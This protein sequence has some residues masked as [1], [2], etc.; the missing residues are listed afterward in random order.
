MWSRRV[1]PVDLRVKLHREHRAIELRE[2]LLTNDETVPTELDAHLAGDNCGTHKTPPSESAVAVGDAWVAGGRVFT[3]A[4][5]EWVQP[6][7]LSDHFD[8][9][10]RLGSLPPIRLHDLR[11]GAATAGTDLKRVQEVLGH[12][13][14]ARTS[15]TH[16]SVLPQ[17][18][19]KRLRQQPA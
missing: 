18:H 19:G 12:S 5:G 6:D 14:L 2:F 3:R 7:W 15:D 13:T 4:T 8:R 17:S 11:H 1:S 9:L 10:R 16:T